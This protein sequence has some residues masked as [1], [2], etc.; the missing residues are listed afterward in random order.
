[1]TTVEVFWLFALVFGIWYKKNETSNQRVKWKALKSMRI[2]GV[3]I[4]ASDSL[5]RQTTCK[6]RSGLIGKTDAGD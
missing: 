3:R 6:L 5:K 2:I 4:E 1:M